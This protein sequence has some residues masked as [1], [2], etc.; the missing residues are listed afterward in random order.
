MTD[1]IVIRGT[2]SIQNGMWYKYLG[3]VGKE[4]YGT[5]IDDKPIRVYPTDKFEIRDDGAVAQVWEPPCR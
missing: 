5:G 4:V 2:N 3:S 1:W